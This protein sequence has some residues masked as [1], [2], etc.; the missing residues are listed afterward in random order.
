MDDQIDHVIA[1]DVEPSE[2]KIESQGQEAHKPD[3]VPR[4]IGEELIQ[5]FNEL[6]LGNPEMVIQNEGDLKGV[7][8]NNDAGQ[9]DKQNCR[10]RPPADKIQDQNR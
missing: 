2:M 9:Q 5:V 4:I 7:G 6:I 8:I 3:I 1:G 10:I